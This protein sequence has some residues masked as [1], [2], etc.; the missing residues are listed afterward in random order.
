MKSVKVRFLIASMLA[1]LLYGAE[2]YAKD[3]NSAS[4]LPASAQ[5]VI[6]K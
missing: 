3:S 2:A 5:F 1:L 4:N 6:N